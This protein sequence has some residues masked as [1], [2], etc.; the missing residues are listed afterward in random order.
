MANDG[1]EWKIAGRK[2]KGKKP[3]V[4]GTNTDNGEL[5]GVPLRDYWQFSV[6]RLEE[7]TTDD[8][9]RRVLHSAGVEVQEVWMLNSKFRGT[10]TA[11]IRVAREHRE[12]AKNQSIWPIHCQIRDWEFG[13]KKADSAQ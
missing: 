11:K 10:K 9:V 4:S 6:T 2:K 13:R 3:S 7:R 12:K 1:N 8:A 5:K